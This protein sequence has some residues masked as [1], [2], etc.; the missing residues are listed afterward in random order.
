MN[1][2]LLKTVITLIMQ[3]HYIDEKIYDDNSLLSDENFFIVIEF[4]KEMKINI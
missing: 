4:I 1:D 3:I 2:I